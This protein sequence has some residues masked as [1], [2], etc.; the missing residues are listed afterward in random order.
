MQPHWLFPTIPALTYNPLF[1]YGS[2]GLGKT[3]LLHAIG[4]KICENNPGSR[5]RYISAESFTVD[6]I[7]SIKKD[8]MP[9]FSEKISTS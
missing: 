6:L 9:L 4:N 7:E 2:V 1:I 8:K 5:I 3:H